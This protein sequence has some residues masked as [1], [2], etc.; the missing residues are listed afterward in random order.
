MNK[1][2]LLLILPY[3]CYSCFFCYLITGDTLLDKNQPDNTLRHF[4]NI[5]NHPLSSENYE[6]IKFDNR[7]NKKTDPVGVLMYDKKNKTH[8]IECRQ[9]NSTTFWKLVLSQI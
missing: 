2:I 7:I 8:Y 5:Q 1:L 4:K 9:P 6:L 3:L